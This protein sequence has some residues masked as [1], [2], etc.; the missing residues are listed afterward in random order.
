MA[1][2]IRAGAKCDAKAYGN[3][4]SAGEV[5]AVQ[6]RPQNPNR[7]VQ[8]GAR[9]CPHL[10]T[11]RGLEVRDELKHVLRKCVGVAGL[12]PQRTKLVI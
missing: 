10:L 2:I 3:P 7:N 12:A 9:N 5:G 1:S 4:S 11:A 6:A 8:S